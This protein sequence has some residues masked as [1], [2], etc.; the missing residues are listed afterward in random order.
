MN[1]QLKSFAFKISDGT[2]VWVN[3]WA[4]E[5]EEEIKGVIQLHHGLAEHSL[6]YDRFGS[7]LAENGYV[8]NAYDMR[9]HGKT[10]EIAEAAGTGKFGKFTDKDGFNRVVDDL[11]EVIEAVKKEYEG[12]P[13][14]L[15]GHSFGSFVSQAYIEKYGNNLAGCVLCGSAGPR[16]LLISAGKLAVTLIKAIRGGDSFVPFLDK[17]AFGNY[18][19]RIPG[20]KTDHDWLSRNE[21][22]VELFFSD[23]WCN[24]PLRTSFYYDM[25]SGLNQIHKAANMKAIPKD[26]PVYFIYGEED[27]VGDYGKTVEKL[28]NIY[29]KNKMQK[30]TLKS[31]PQD[32]HE[33][34][35]EVD[36]ETVEKD[37]LNWLESVLKK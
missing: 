27:P 12:K 16:K 24:I 30:V 15:F 31:Y 29:L 25:M 20:N 14:I 17:L 11:N 33:I 32:R 5:P 8:L 26:L 36:K 35:N 13:V 34:L 22:N 9:G 3:R 4:P 28:Y 2:E 7:V 10:A 37:V 6:R 1:M 19:N 23:K 21:L 18:N